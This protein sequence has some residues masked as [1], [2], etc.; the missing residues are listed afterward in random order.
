MKRSWVLAAVLIAFV[1]Q[2]VF[3][4]SN[5]LSDQCINGSC[6]ILARTSPVGL[7]SAAALLALTVF[8]HPI[9]AAPVAGQTVRLRR[10]VGAFFIDIFAAMMIVIPLAALLMLLY[11][12]A[13]SKAF[14]WAVQVSPPDW[15]DHVIAVVLVI[16]AFAGL[17]AYYQLPLRRG[18]QTLG[19]YVLGYRLEPSEDGKPHYAKLRILSVV[20]V[21]FWPISLAMALSR[22]DREFWWNHASGVQAVSLNQT[23]SSPAS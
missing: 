4:V 8:L 9:P 11:A 23:P 16:G 7:L 10:R 17:I 22:P 13:M 5:V 12:A 15:W 18:R 21:C 3:G 14:A 6:V 1:V 2:S 19:Q 20:G